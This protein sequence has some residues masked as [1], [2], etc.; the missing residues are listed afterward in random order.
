MHC[1]D[2]SNGIQYQVFDTRH[3]YEFTHKAG[4]K[5]TLDECVR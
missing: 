5:E 1:S 3:G 4:V 2:W